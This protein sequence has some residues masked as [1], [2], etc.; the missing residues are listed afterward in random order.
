MKIGFLQ[1]GF[2]PT[3][4]RSLFDNYLSM[5][6]D[7]FA[8]YDQTI[9]LI[10]FPVQKGVFP[11]KVNELGG[12]LCCGSAHS[13][14][15]NNPWINELIGFIREVEQRG[16]KMVGICFGHQ[17]IAHALGGQVER[18]KQGWGLGVH[19]VTTTQSRPWMQPSINRFN[20]LYTHQDQVVKLPEGATLLGSSN[21]CPIAAYDLENRFLG[22]QGHP[23]FEVPFL[24]A[25]METRKKRIGR[26]A[27]QWA[28]T[29]LNQPLHNREIALWISHFFQQPHRATLS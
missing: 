26:N 28:A 22:I 17:L 1:A 20:L 7:L 3:S 13:A 21:H 23:E 29:T 25:L 16:P 24:Q 4:L 10:D 15:D 12:Y 19:N 6:K 5:F 14:Y 11:T 2:P 8:R 27:V 9:E 18:A